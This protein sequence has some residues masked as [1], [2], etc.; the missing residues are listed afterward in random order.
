MRGESF[1]YAGAVNA[2]I[3]DYLERGEDPTQGDSLSVRELEILKLVA[4]GRT[5]REIA[6]IFVLA[7]KTVERHRSNILA[8]LGMRDRVDLTRY[9]IRR[10]LIE[11]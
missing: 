11:P 8:K 4:E 3:R 2:L 9:A 5:T 6:D 10:G 7:E 1:V